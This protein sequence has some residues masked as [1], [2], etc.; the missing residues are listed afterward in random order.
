MTNDQAIKRFE[1]ALNYIQE[2]YATFSE[3]E[4]AFRND[5]CNQKGMP[6]YEETFEMYQL[7]IQALKKQF[8][9]KWKFSETVTAYY[10]PRCLAQPVDVEQ[11]YC[12]W[13]GQKLEVSDGD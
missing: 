12:H 9:R 11:K 8:T 13:C 2:Q 10:C 4:K 6:T 7:A 3:N 5:M 1:T